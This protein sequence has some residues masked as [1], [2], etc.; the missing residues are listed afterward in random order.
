MT[1]D[2]LIIFVVFF[3]GYALSMKYF[4]G[5]GLRLRVGS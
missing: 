2:K 1:V 5:I 3:S 4:T